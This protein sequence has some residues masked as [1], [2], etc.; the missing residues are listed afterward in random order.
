MNLVGAGDVNLVSPERK[1][2]DV[3]ARRKAGYAIPEAD[4]ERAEYDALFAEASKNPTT[5]PTEKAKR[6]RELHAKFGA[7]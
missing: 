7:K 5:F 6:L 1:A 3:E 4:P 2:A